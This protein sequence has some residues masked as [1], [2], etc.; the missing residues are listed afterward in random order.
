MHIDRIDGID[1]LDTPAVAQRWI[2]TLTADVTGSAGTVNDQ[3]LFPALTP[4]GALAGSGA[5]DA[6][7]WS[8]RLNQTVRAAGIY[9]GLPDADVRYR[10]VSG[11]SLRRGIITTAVDAGVDLTAVKQHVRHSDLSMT[12]RYVD[13]LVGRNVNWNDT[14]HRYLTG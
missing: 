14:V 11:H 13:D 3:P 1:V 2:D 12:S 9:D 10:N 7:H 8:E 4:A 5:M 6:Q